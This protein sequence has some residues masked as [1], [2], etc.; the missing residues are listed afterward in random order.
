VNLETDPQRA[1]QLCRE[2]QARLM[3]QVAHLSDNGIR[4][5]SLLPDWTLAHVLTHLARNADADLH[6]VVLDHE[7]SISSSTSRGEQRR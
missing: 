5:P 7:S 6:A 2:A 1:S 4:S 3:Q